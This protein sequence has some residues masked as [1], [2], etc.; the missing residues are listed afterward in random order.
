MQDH[1]GAALVGRM[2][3]GMKERDGERTLLEVARQRA[4]GWWGANETVGM[5]GDLRETAAGG[6]CWTTRSNHGNHSG[7]SKCDGAEGRN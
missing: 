1:G 3:G 6:G 7:S 4:A 2:S 5:S